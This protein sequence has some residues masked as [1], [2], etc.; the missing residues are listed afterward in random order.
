MWKNR[1]EYQ[2]LFETEDELTEY[3][4]MMG[5][6][7]IWGGDLELSILSK[8]LQCSF[9]IHANNRPDITVSFLM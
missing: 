1:E 9:V 3:I 7:H 6:D 5:K 8:I 4:Q 2:C